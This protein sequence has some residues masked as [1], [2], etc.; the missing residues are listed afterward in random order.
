M[1]LLQSFLSLH[2]Y[3]LLQPCSS[4]THALILPGAPAP[5]SGSF[6]LHDSELYHL[7]YC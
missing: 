5:S 4:P 7:V 2:G 6:K 3:G 1:G